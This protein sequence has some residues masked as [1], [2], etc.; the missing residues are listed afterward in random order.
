MFCSIFKS[1]PLAGIK[2]LGGR[3]GAERVAQINSPLPSASVPRLKH[4]SLYMSD[5]Y[6]C[7]QYLL[8]LS[9]IFRLCWLWRNR[10]LVWDIVRGKFAKQLLSVF[11]LPNEVI[12]YVYKD[13]SIC[14]VLVNMQHHEVVQVGLSLV[15]FDPFCFWLFWCLISRYFKAVGCFWQSKNTISFIYT[16]PNCTEEQ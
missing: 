10:E 16:I 13:Q 1:R 8:F 6:I 2:W 12:S 3:G 7:L 15:H 4:T 11:F 5:H 14:S 9:I